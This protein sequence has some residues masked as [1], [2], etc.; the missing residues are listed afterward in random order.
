MLQHLGTVH[1][2]LHAM[3]AVHAVPDCVCT[4]V[5]W[6]HRP[7][8]SGQLHP[9]NKQLPTLAS[10]LARHHASCSQAL[11]QQPAALFG[12]TKHTCPAALTRQHAL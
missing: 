5:C 8:A 11:D 10:C 6:E 4:Y 1:G 3:C 2:M 7:G 9:P 12:T